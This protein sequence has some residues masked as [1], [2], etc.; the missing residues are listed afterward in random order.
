MGARQ[1]IGTMMASPMMQT[2]AIIPAVPWW[3]LRAVREIPIPMDWMI[4]KMTV[5]T[6]MVN[7][8]MM[9]VQTRMQMQTGFPMVRIPVTI[10]GVRW[11]IPGDVPGTQTQ[12]D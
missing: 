7:G 1:P 4:V 11:W 9:D 10:Q 5:P 3:I 12:M 2:P 6:S 8:R